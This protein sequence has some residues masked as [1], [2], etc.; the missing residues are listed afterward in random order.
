MKSRKPQ[1][2]LEYYLLA[3]FSFELNYRSITE[4][5]LLY[6]PFLEYVETINN[7]KIL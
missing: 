4:K 3:N 5:Y 6:I 7:P 2:T 1:T